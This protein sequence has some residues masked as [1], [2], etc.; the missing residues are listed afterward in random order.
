MKLHWPGKKRSK[1]VEVVCYVLSKNHISYINVFILVSALLL[2][3]FK[4]IAAPLFDVVLNRTLKKLH[5]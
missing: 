5:S 3:Y 1:T 4:C 2:Q